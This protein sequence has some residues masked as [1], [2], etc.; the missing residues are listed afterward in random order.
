[1]RYPA[2]VRRESIGC[3]IK[4]SS[5]SL[6]GT[7]APLIVLVLPAGTPEQASSI[8]EDFL[9]KARNI[10]GT[11]D[12]AGSTPA[13]LP[14]AEKNGPLWWATQRGRRFHTY[15]QLLSLQREK[16]ARFT[17]VK[18]AWHLTRLQLVKCRSVACRESPRFQSKTDWA[19]SRPCG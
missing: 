4:D 16:W 7:L 14:R 19:G 15:Y 3:A 12:L 11:Q 9:S 10:L 5:L 8:S 18:Q 13:V 6:A 1:M 2:Q 17:V